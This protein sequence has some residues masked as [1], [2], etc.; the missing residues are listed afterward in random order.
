MLI[1]LQPYLLDWH[2]WEMQKTRSK[3]K[4][5]GPVSPGSLRPHTTDHEDWCSFGVFAGWQA[6]MVFIDWCSQLPK[7][8]LAVCKLAARLT[9]FIIFYRTMMIDLHSMAICN[10]AMSSRLNGCFL[11]VSGK[12]QCHTSNYLTRMVI[13]RRKNGKKKKM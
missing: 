1:C 4:P 9:W 6:R 13:E 3:Q 8:K 12:L 10:I 7:L 5:C 2:E 11:A